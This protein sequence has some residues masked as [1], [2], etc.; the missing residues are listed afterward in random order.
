MKAVW[1]MAACFLAQSASAAA[2]FVGSQACRGCHLAIFES[3]APTPMARSSGKV[4]SVPAA[5]SSAAGHRYKILENRLIFDEGSASFSYFIGSNT[6]GR[7]YAT[8]RDGYL[9]ELPVTWY[10]RNHVWD[11]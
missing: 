6:A 3:S 9:F 2:L 7:T 5:E 4:A 10:V 8:E 11:A 1:G